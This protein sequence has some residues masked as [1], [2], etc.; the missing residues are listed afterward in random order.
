MMHFI[1]LRYNCEDP[2]CYKDLARLRGVKYFTWENTTKLVQQD[3]VRSYCNLLLN[4][5]Y[6]DFGIKNSMTNKIE[7]PVRKNHIK[8][9]FLVKIFLVVVNIST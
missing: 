6:I 8:L 4:K 9:F 1:F 7:L 2:N 3:P 5:R